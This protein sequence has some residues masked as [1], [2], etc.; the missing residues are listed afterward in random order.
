MTR[1]CQFT[2]RCRRGGHVQ[3]L[4]L[5]GPR[6]RAP[7][8]SNTRVCAHMYVCVRNPCERSQVAGEE[9]GSRWVRMG[10]GC[11]SS[12]CWPQS[13]G[14]QAEQPGAGSWASRSS[15]EAPR[16]L[17]CCRSSRVTLWVQPS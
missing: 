11:L 5:L 12:G 7:G 8:S 13:S 15:P 16:G 6:R 3:P 9:Q 14:S 10:S 2:S 4:W 1:W 17:G